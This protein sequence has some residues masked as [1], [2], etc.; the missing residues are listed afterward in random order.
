MSSKPTLFSSTI[1]K[2]ILA[3]LSFSKINQEPKRKFSRLW[4]KSSKSEAR[5]SMIMCFSRRNTLNFRTKNEKDIELN[6]NL[7]LL[8]YKKYFNSWIFNFRFSYIFYQLLDIFLQFFPN[9]LTFRFLNFVSGHYFHLK[10][11][12]SAIT[13]LFKK[14]LPKTIKLVY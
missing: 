13:V 1:F 10:I 8:E 3:W 2:A 6:C 7:F 9:K 12:F 14:F 5:N 4:T 11:F